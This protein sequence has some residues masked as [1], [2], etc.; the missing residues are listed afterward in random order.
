MNIRVHSIVTLMAEAG[1][2]LCKAESFS[3][4]GMFFAGRFMTH[5]TAHL[6]DRVNNGIVHQVSMT[7][8]AT[9]ICF[10]GKI[11]PGVT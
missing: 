1:K 10:I 3:L 11:L 9:F 5:F 6:K 8:Q 2:I 4:T 7:F